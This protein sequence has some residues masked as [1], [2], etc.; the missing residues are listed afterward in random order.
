MAPTTAIFAFGP[1]LLYFSTNSTKHVLEAQ[2]YK[3]SI[4]TRL[5]FI[6]KKIYKK[7][8]QDGVFQIF[9]AFL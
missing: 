4:F 8:I 1:Q 9:Y 5:I 3:L 6:F 2:S 7:N